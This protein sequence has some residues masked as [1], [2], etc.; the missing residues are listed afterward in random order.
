MD[1]S[2]SPKL[3][4][5]DSELNPTDTQA[6]KRSRKVVEKIVVTVKVGENGGKLKSEGPPSDLWS[7]RKYGQKPIKGSPYPRGYYRCSTSKGCSAKK[8]VERCKTDASMLIITYTSSHN[9]PGPDLHCA[10]LKQSPKEPQTTHSDDDKPPTTTLKQL[11]EVSE[12][13][14]EEVKKEQNKTSSTDEDASEEQHFHYLQSPL[15]FPQNNIISQEDPF[16][17]NLEKTHDT[18]EFLLDEEPLSCLHI[19][20]SSIPKS[21]ENDFFDELEELPISSAFTSLMMRSKFWDEGIPVVP[22]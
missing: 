21:E 12:K 16:N 2:V 11:P 7:W 3:A 15:S 8:Q 4:S 22:S 13:E 14:P 9:H 18:L 20:T 1:D 6:S 17:G 19:T 10:D 5:D